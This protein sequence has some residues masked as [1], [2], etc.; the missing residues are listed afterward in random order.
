MKKMIA[1]IICAVLSAF[2]CGCG[3]YSITCLLD[4]ANN[5]SMEIEIFVPKEGLTKDEISSVE[6]SFGELLTYWAG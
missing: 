5:A 3:R 1:V 4:D 2:F 6:V